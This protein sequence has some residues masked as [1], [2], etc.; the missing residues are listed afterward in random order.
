M[1]NFKTKMH[2][3]TNASDWQWIMN[4]HEELNYNSYE[5]NET[6]VTY[7]LRRSYHAYK[8]MD[9]YLVTMVKKI[10]RNLRKLKKKSKETFRKHFSS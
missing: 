4:N 2:Q 1:L 7:R 5:I 8:D 9:P 10:W 6:I 3:I